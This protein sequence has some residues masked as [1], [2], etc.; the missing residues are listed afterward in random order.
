M[1]S[2]RKNKR[3]CYACLDHLRQICPRDYR[4]DRNLY[5]ACTLNVLKHRYVKEKNPRGL[6]RFDFVCFILG[7]LHFVSRFQ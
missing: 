5:R 4:F 1:L 3:I 2:V 6:N 7:N